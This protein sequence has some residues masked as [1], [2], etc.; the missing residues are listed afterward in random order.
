MVKAETQN[1]QL[2]DIDS[3]SIRQRT[4]AYGVLIRDGKILMIKTHSDNWELPGGTPEPGETLVQGLKRELLEETATH[5]SI[6]R[7][8]YI[9]E[10]FYHSPSGK[11]YHSLQFY[12]LITTDDEPSDAGSRQYAFMPLEEIT[13]QTT[14]NSAYLALQ[15]FREDELTCDLWSH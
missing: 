8:F 10:S 3:R 2:V 13:E 6:G 14:N 15:N 5:A 12:F 9:R 4:S 11:S 1:K 7:L